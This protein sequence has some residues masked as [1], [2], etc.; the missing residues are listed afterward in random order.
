LRSKLDGLARDF[1]VYP[2][3][4]RVSDRNPPPLG[5][6]KNGSKHT[7]SSDASVRLFE[8][9]NRFF[10]DDSGQ[11]EFPDKSLDFFVSP[12]QVR[13]GVGSRIFNRVPKRGKF[14]ACATKSSIWDAAGPEN[15]TSKIWGQCGRGDLETAFAVA[16]VPELLGLPYDAASASAYL[17]VVRGFGGFFGEH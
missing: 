10:P 13:F 8:N 11:F 4:I 16:F 5:R 12:F 2:R 3:Q 1:N 17:G 7:R 9:V 15:G 6:K 14:W